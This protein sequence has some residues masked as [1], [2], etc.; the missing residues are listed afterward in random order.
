[1]LSPRTSPRAVLPQS[2]R[3]TLFEAERLSV[4]VSWYA[5]GLRMHRHAH[6]CHQ[7]S[8]LLMGTLGEQGPRDDVRLATPAVGIKPAGA[9]HA[10]DYGPVGA[11]ILGFNLP[12]AFNLP[13]ALGSSD[14]AQWR[15]DPP[16]ALLAQGRSTLAQLLAGATAACDTEAMLWELLATV[17]SV[18]PRPSGT[19]PLWIAR[20]C[21]RLQQE[22]ASLTVLAQE[23]GLHPVYFA[24]AFARWMGCTPSTFRTRAQ[25]QRALPLLAAGQPLAMVALHAG[26]ADQAHFSRVARQHSGLTPARLRGLLGD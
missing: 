25:L 12:P 3:R 5:P 8:L 18:P 22:A 6:D 19:P 1:M 9:V 24:R 10:N 15:L 16:P 21:E 26:F 23:Q 13:D 2:R 7:V 20:V 17:G 4:R 14:A 11:L